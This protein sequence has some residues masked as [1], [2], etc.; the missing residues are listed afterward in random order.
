MK[1]DAVLIDVSRGGVV[2]EAA[3]LDALRSARI[4]GAALDVFATEPLPE[5]HPLWNFDNVIVTP[6]CSSVYKGW[7]VKSAEMFSANLARYRH[8]ELLENVVDPARGY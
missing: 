8:N 1:P 6:H 5:Q 4:K 7:E 3:L 2:V